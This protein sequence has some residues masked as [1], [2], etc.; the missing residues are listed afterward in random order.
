MSDE[1]TMPWGSA[2]PSPPGR[3]DATTQTAG[4]ELL[5]ED[6]VRGI[7]TEPDEAHRETNADPLRD[8][9]LPR[10][11]EPTSDFSP[12]DPDVST[13]PDRLVAGRYRMERVLGRGGF[14]VVHLAYD[15]ELH[16]SVAIKITRAS[17][18]QAVDQLL[19]EG[20]KVA[21]LDHPCIVP[22]YDCGRLDGGFIY[23]VSKF[24]DGGSLADRLA[25]R[26]LPI[27]EVV[28]VALQVA[29]A[30]GHAHTRGIVHRDV[31]PKNILLD[32]HGGLYLADFGLALRD[33][34]RSETTHVEGSPAYMSPEQASGRS[35]MVDQRTDLF[36]FGIVLYEML[37]GRRPFRGATIEEILRKLRHEHPKP[38][39]HVNPEIPARLERI[40]LKALE[41][42]PRDRYDSAPEIERDLRSLCPPAAPDHVQIALAACAVLVVLAL[43]LVLGFAV[44]RSGVSD[45]GGPLPAVPPTQGEAARTERQVAEWVLRR[46]GTLDVADHLPPTIGSLAGLPKGAFSL[47]SI[48]MHGI[49]PL[50]PQDVHRLCKIKSLRHLHLSD[51]KISDLDLIPIGQLTGLKSLWINYNDLSDEGIVSLGGLKDLQRLNLGW[52]NVSDDGVDAISSALDLG[53]LDL[54]N[55]SI[56]DR[57]VKSL[58]GL[59]RLRVLLLNQTQITDA[60]LDDLCRLKGLQSLEISQTRLTGPA[61]QKLEDALPGCR[62]VY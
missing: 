10:E 45:R 17:S 44:S 37:T 4:R 33:I 2:S 12:G 21:Q 28:N 14:G 48:D 47:L 26:P 5:P 51:T 59:K 43:A 41:K 7:L 31:K 34:D 16:R 57:A 3:P 60:C 19:E 35:R 50:S 32:S 53:F 9:E 13:L 24:I 15:V 18:P 25:G 29:S 56:S 58:G 39:R 46:G 11:M 22:V 38:P 23:I 54:S 62:I 1:N 52:T 36:S 20:R 27:D 61:L 6:R 49:K 40:C 55:T 8:V 42:D 30:L